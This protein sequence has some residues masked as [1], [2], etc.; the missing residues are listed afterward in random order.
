MAV[1]GIALH[2]WP[3]CLPLGVS[4]AISY[5]VTEGCVFTQVFFSIS[6][7]FVNQIHLGTLQIHRFQSVSNFHWHI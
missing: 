3:Q 5:K 1:E 4:P 6:Y 2:F 7:F